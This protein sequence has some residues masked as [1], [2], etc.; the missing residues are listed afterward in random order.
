MDRTVWIRRRAVSALVVAVSA[1]GLTGCGDDGSTGMSTG[2]E[3]ASSI[4][5]SLRTVEGAA[6]DTTDFVLDGARAEAVETATELNEAAQGRA[7]ADLTA[8]GAPAAQIEELKVRAAHVAKIAPSGRPI[9]VAI[10][11]NR[12]FELVPGFFALYSDPVPSDVIRLDYLDFE[13]KLRAIAGDRT[14]ARVAVGE[15]ARVWNGLRGE[16]ASEGG[17]AAAASFDAHVARIQKLLEDG[18]DRMLAAE[19]QHGLDLV[20]EVEVVYGG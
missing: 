5:E 2:A 3:G 13:T 9:E 16:V 4:P 1:I 18:S 12:A 19:A 15:L 6:E 10:A 11:A 20:D 14:A 7:S 17:Q 8:A